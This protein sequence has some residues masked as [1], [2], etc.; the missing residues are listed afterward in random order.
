MLQYYLY[1]ETVHH[2][3]VPVIAGDTTGWTPQ[4]FTNFETINTPAGVP[5]NK[6]LWLTEA[7]YQA[8]DLAH[9]RI[10]GDPPALTISV[11]WAREV[12]TNRL[13]L[14]REHRWP[15]VDILMLRAIEHGNESERNTIRNY[16]RKMRD[17]PT[18]SKLT[19]TTDVSVL[20]AYDL[21]TIVGAVPDLF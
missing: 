16:K 14:E 8:A 11:E 20:A 18:F 21:D 1:E 17:F 9:S 7:D 2:H 4:D 13:R 19:N 15:E 6:R 10:T 12:A 3:I 5:A